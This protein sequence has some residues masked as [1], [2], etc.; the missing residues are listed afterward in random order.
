MSDK[1][2]ID[3]YYIRGGDI[4][5]LIAEA[6]D[7]PPIP[8]ELRQKLNVRNFWSN[9]QDGD[10]IF[11]LTGAH[12]PR[13]S[14]NRVVE[15]V[16]ISKS[17]TI[18]AATWLDGARRVDAKT[19]APGEDR[20]IE[21]KVPQET[22]WLHAP[23]VRTYNEYRPPTI[24][25][26]GDPSLAGPWRDHVVRLFPNEHDH[27]V[28]WLA[29]RV[30]HPGV[31][32]N[33]AIVMGG[34]QGI[35]KDTILQPV[36]AAVG[37]S[38]YA[39]VS[40]SQITGKFNAFFKNTIVVVSEVRDTGE[41]T[42]FDLYELTKTHTSSPPEFIQIEEK[43]EKAHHIPNVVGLIYTTNHR[44]GSMYLPP[45]DRRHFVGWSEVTAEAL[46]AEFG[47][48]YFDNLWRWLEE[49]GGN[50][51]VAA[52]LRALDLTNFDPKA[53]PPKTEAFWAMVHAF[54]SEESQELADVIEQL[55]S[56]DVLT[57]RMLD[58]AY[59]VQSNTYDFSEFR[60]NRQEPRPADYRRETFWQDRKNR[61]RIPFLMDEVGY[62]V[63]RNPS[64]KDGRWKV[65]REN[66]TI[67]ARNALP[68]QERLAAA[69][70]FLA[71]P[72]AKAR[73]PMTR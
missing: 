19:W 38:N 69:M 9:P 54:Q 6:V 27:L 25:E 47:Q 16:R 10:Y 48:D 59:A 50:A 14:V 26:T 60:E 51:H 1:Q 62:V 65:N 44:I 46:K 11:E 67:Y 70:A 56:P 58:D 39:E 45:G 42:R 13:A 64:T 28:Q 22:G 63:V 32:V 57:L 12:W 30:Q 41:F 40:P 52:Y 20:I 37:A 36:L 31:K 35:G 8:P 23:G 15:K 18:P 53:P 49:E 17:E 24:D 29:H 4:A 72:A 55:G 34:A 73:V 43:Y 33:H 66:T 21:G 3:D 71:Q 2:G 5:V 7:E 61:R 68:V